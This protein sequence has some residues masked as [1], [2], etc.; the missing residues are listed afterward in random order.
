MGSN[1]LKSSNK[2]NQKIEK[3]NLKKEKS[4]FSPGSCH[5]P[6]LKVLRPVARQPP[7]WPGL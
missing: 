1:R 2:N 6:G 7:T 4:P 3:R 5:K